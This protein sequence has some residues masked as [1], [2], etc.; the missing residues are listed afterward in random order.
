MHRQTL[1][2]PAL[3]M[4]LVMTLAVTVFTAQAAT[5]AC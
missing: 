5:G 1:T 2:P 3:V 4:T